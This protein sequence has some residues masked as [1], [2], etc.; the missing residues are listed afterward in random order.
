MSI[1]SKW[2]WEIQISINCDV[3]YLCLLMEK[4]PTTLFINQYIILRDPSTLSI[5]ADNLTKYQSFSSGCM[6]NHV[7]SVKKKQL[8][9]N[10][11]A[12]LYLSMN[13][14]SDT[15]RISLQAKNIVSTIPPCEIYVLS[16]H[17]DL[18]L[19]KSETFLLKKFNQFYLNNLDLYLARLSCEASLKGLHNICTTKVSASYLK[20]PTF[21]MTLTID[22]KTSKNIVDNLSYLMGQ[23]TSLSNLL[24]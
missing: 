7:H 10:N 1:A 5:L 17:Y 24:A 15:G 6:L 12:G 9:S 16:N 21:N 8:I 22:T 19:Y 18:S 20:S 2:K 13:S 11:S 3:D 14:Y 4:I 23:I